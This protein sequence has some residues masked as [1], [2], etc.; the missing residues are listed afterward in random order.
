MGQQG[1]IL[2]GTCRA[3]GYSLEGITSRRCPECGGEFDPADWTTMSYPRLLGEFWGRAPG[4]LVLALSAVAIVSSI[5]AYSRPLPSEFGRRLGAAAWLVAGVLVGTRLV[6]RLLLPARLFQRRADPRVFSRRVTIFVLA[7]LTVCVLIGVRAP[8][9]ARLW[10]SLPALNRA[11]T[12][13]RERPGGTRGVEEWI[14]AFRVIAVYQPGGTVAFPLRAGGTIVYAPAGG[15]V[16]FRGAGGFEY[17]FKL[18]R[19]WGD[20]YSAE[21]K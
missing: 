11:V 21:W 3:C 7:F 12:K 13:A 8:L 9:A 1:P 4:L 17:E 19:I 16:Q 15:P 6:I 14:G 10:V 2:R 20:W 5:L 18:T